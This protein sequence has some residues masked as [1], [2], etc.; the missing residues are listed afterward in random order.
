MTAVLVVAVTGGPAVAAPMGPLSGAPDEETAEAAEAMTAQKAAEVEEGEAG[1]SAGVAPATPAAVPAPPTGP[2]PADYVTF[3]LP[4]PAERGGGT[5]VG[6]A[7][8]IEYESAD[9]VQLTQGVELR[10][11]GIR[12]QAQ[13]MTAD[14]GA[15]T[16]F[17]E[18]EVILDQG[19][20]R[21]VAATLEF[22]LQSKDAVFKDATA[23]VDP[24]FFFSG[25][26]IRKVGEDVYE[27][28]H[29]TLTS[30]TDLTPDWSFRVSRARIKV[31]GFARAWNVR[32][33]VKKLP[34]LYTP[35]ILW[36]AQSDRT[37]GFLV[38]N[39]GYGDLRGFY[40]G[41]AYYQTLGRSADMTLYADLWEK[42]YY[43]LG[44]ELRYVPSETSR[45]DLEAFVID[46]PVDDKTRWKA[47]WKHVAD[48]LPWGFRGVL[49]YEDYSD[50]EYFRD[51]ERDFEDVSKR[52]VYS[53]AYVSKNFGTQSFNLLVDDRETIL[54]GD[55]TIDQRQL[56]EIEYK[57]R[58]TQLGNLPL[59]LELESSAHYLLNRRSEA[60]DSTYGR[61]DLFPRLTVPFSAWPW[62]SLSLTGGA[63]YTWY[64]D[65]L[66][67]DGKA[68]SGESL[69]RTL[70]TGN[71]EIVGPSFS[72]IFGRPLG[73][74][75]KF[76]HIVEPRWDYTFTSAFDE[77]AEVPVFDEIDQ[78]RSRNLGSFSLVNRLLAKPEDVLGEGDAREIIS[79]TL[80]QQYSFD[81]DKPL[82]RSADREQE[83]QLG[84]LAARLRFKPG[85]RLNLDTQATWS[86]LFDTISS[87]SLSGT[88]DWGPSSVGLTW[89][90]RFRVE[91][92]KTQSNQVRLSTDL[93]L[94][95][96]RW[97]L[98]AQ[99]YYD[100]QLQDF[101]QQRYIIRYNSEC[102]GLRFEVREL[103]LSNR[104]TLDYRFAL[105]LKNV[106]TFI[107][108]NGGDR[109]ARR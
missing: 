47:K 54:S 86:N 69:S 101:Q 33:R 75:S 72:R 85:D 5:L 34:I 20:R 12:I 13:R 44:T 18:G 61:A 36:P 58:S 63:R 19:P 56:P 23:Y 60:L 7:G 38:P 89:F 81:E 26:Q 80:T 66:T 106:G 3:T 45:G 11:Q 92:R 35:Y 105:S 9:R 53:S 96:G 77:F 98:Y 52:S 40:L 67:P 27:L 4:L 28:D 37:S 87:T 17:A 30:C 32:M 25:E 21:I 41:L 74:F 57:I 2:P 29:G 109:G 15:E 6:S 76:K 83:S 103:T 49:D 8:S 46:D 14:L 88:Y 64:G 95:G 43:G 31:E 1:E 97:G 39:I 90:T 70:P 79:F 99:L 42:E 62:L 48:E 51:F 24:D 82:E 65:S 100:F 10:F 107:D 91:E 22:K 94:F 108:L 73:G 102:Y 68:Y 78:V 55:R 71:V 50:F 93:D 16:V 59:Y 84:P 104:K